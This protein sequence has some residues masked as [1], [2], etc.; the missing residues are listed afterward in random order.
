MYYDCA[1]TGTSPTEDCG[2]CAYGGGPAAGGCYWDPAL[3]GACSPYWSSTQG[4]TGMWIIQF[5]YA[6]FEMFNYVNGNAYVRCVR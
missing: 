1:R 6:G 5:N 4:P 3:G 2:G